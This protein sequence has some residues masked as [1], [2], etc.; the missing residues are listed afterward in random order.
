[1]RKLTLIAAM[2]L[3]PAIAVADTYL[4]PG[5]PSL[6]IINTGFEDCA[7]GDIHLQTA[8]S[9]GGHKWGNY[10]LTV[11]VIDDPFG[12]GHG[13]VLGWLPPALPEGETRTKHRLYVDRKDYDWEIR[14]T[15]GFTTWA[16]D[17]FLVSNLGDWTNGGDME[18]GP[19]SVFW[20]DNGAITPGETIEAYLTGP[21]WDPFHVDS[22]SQT[23]GPIQKDTWFSMTMVY[24]YP[25]DTVDYYIDGVP[26]A[27]GLP[28]YWNTSQSVHFELWLEDDFLEGMG[29]P[30]MLVDNVHYYWQIPEP[31]V[32]LLGGLGLLA[33]LRGGRS[34]IAKTQAY[35][36]RSEPSHAGARF[37]LLSHGAT[38]A[39]E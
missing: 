33:L 34:S 21:Q 20:L 4:T 39:C 3:L 29:I 8:P 5:V 12:T 30:Y 26:V 7:Y 6:D 11:D 16:F 22:T 19:N 37:A 23:L 9:L 14:Y 27:S 10:D 38:D 32:L 15:T 36:N 24:N 28:T 18:G 31:S 1:M 13:K 25:T 35:L 17:L 2:L